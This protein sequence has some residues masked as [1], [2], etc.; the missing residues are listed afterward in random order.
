MG[1]IFISYRREGGSGYAISLYDRLVKQFGQ[2]QVFKD[3]EAIQPGTDF[4][5]EIEGA[6][7]SCDVLIAMIGKT[8]L[9]SKDDMGN[10]RLDN[11]EDFVRI[12]IN[13]ALERN[14]RVIPVLVGGATMPKAQ[15]LPDNLVNLTKRQ[16]M[17]ISDKRF[18]SDMDA[19]IQSIKSVVP[20]TGDFW[21][22]CRK[23]VKSGWKQRSSFAKMIENDMLFFKHHKIFWIAFIILI[24]WNL[25]NYLLSFLI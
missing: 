9:I 20:M 23:S 6:V 24:I 18:H 16:A 21:T 1:G 25:F 5:K 12:E 17:E 11:P 2:E 13:T 7:S 19:L 4:E 14:I 3:I 10:R 8:W 22:D 15:E